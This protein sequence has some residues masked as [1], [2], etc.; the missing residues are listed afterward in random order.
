MASDR[1]PRY[2]LKFRGPLSRQLVRWIER[3][4][5][6]LREVPSD[7]TVIVEVETHVPIDD[8]ETGEA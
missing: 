6:L 8:D 1:G 4:I 5:P 7:T 2:R 3:L